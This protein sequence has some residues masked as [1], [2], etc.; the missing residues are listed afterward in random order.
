[1]TGQL[2]GAAP[3][4]KWTWKPSAFLPYVV[5]VV[6]VTGADTLAIEAASVVK[7]DATSSHVHIHGAAAPR[8]PLGTSEAPVWFTSRNDDAVGG[9]TN[10]DGG[11]TLPAGGDWQAV[12]LNNSCTTDLNGTHFA[13]G[14][15][16]GQANIITSS[17]V[18]ANFVWNGGGAYGSANDG[19]R[20]NCTDASLS[21][22]EAS[23]NAAD[24]IASTWPGSWVEPRPIESGR[25][26]R[27]RRSPM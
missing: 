9:D 14:G 25:G 16:A 1:V 26:K 12:Y 2:G 19:V 13:Y 3:D 22:L 8:R 4:G 18:I 17:G 7:F 20:V 6:T 5:G 11:A 15:G 23:Y 24:G 10:N 27:T 21:S